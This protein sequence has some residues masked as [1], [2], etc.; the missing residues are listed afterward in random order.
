MEFFN[1]IVTS[2]YF[3]Y[4]KCYLEHILVY[5]IVLI[6]NYNALIIVLYLLQL[7]KDLLN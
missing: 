1:K 5:F 4:I 3:I 2:I 7:S 6:N